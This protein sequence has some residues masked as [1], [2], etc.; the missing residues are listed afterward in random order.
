MSKYTPTQVES[1]IDEYAEAAFPREE[2][3]LEVVTD[4]LHAY[5]AALREREAAK[6][7]DRL[8]SDS[9]E[10]VAQW[11]YANGHHD[12]AATVRGQLD[13]RNH[14][15]SELKDVIAR[16]SDAAKGGVTGVEVLYTSDEVSEAM[17]LLRHYRSAIPSECLDQMEAVLRAAIE[18]VWPMVGKPAAPKGWKLVPV[19][20]T[21]EM[22]RAAH[23]AWQRIMEMGALRPNDT[24]MLFVMFDAM[25]SAAPT[26]PTSGEVGE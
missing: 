3:D 24:T 19:R 22:S 8:H 4:M 5:A 9:A 15:I 26:P 6:G 1:A 13:V 23:A 16:Q 21:A 10:D 12:A 14:R 25:L 2:I 20:P 18:A 7:D 17:E 11:L